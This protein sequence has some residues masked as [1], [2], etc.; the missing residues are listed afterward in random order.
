[1]VLKE[2]PPDEIN[3][4]PILQHLMSW[5]KLIRN[6]PKDFWMEELISC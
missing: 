4:I 1:M 3:I 6:K 2:I 5:L